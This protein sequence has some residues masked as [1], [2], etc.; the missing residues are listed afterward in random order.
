MRVL[1]LHCVELS[2]MLCQEQEV[3][4]APVFMRSIATRGVPVLELTQ[5]IN[6][7]SVVSLLVTC[8]KS[9]EIKCNSSVSLS[10]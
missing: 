7:H 3:Q 4:E 8:V 6:M 9:V 1:E 5:Y 2:Q 10:L